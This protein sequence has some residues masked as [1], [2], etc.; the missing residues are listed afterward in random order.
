VDKQG[1]VLTQMADVI[2]RQ[3]KVDFDAWKSWPTHSVEEKVYPADVMK[4]I[5]DEAME[6]R[7]IVRRVTGTEGFMG[8]HGDG[9][10][11]MTPGEYD[12][13]ARELLRLYEANTA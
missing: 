3:H 6:S 12:R 13:L 5:G 11:R 4:R 1:K 10:I 8:V 2:E 9:S 7:A